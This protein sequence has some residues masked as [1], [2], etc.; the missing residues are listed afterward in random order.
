VS[1][2][3]LAKAIRVCT[4]AIILVVVITILPSCVSQTPTAPTY[5]LQ[6]DGVDDYVALNSTLSLGTFTVEA[7]MYHDA[8]NSTTGILLG[9]DSNQNWIR[10]E[11]T[12]W[13]L[14]MGGTVYYISSTIS[15]P[16]AEWI[17]VAIVR[18]GTTC[19]IFLSGV[20]DGSTTVDG[21]E[22]FSPK[23]I[24]GETS[25]NR[26]M[27][28]K[29]NNVRVWNCASTQSQIKAD[30]YSELTGT[31]VGLVGYWKLNEGSGT[32][33]YDSSGNNNNGRL[34]GNPLWFTGGG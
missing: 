34:H 18:E 20:P 4:I 11:T 5:G 6:F 19:T 17:H 21:S 23:N 16:L 28:G 27:D 13:T 22:T 9:D 33:A 24:G 7:W 12:Q 10:I 31:E 32:I 30:M 3:K 15:T 1:N 14:R 2:R 26:C 25:S 29:L 8:L